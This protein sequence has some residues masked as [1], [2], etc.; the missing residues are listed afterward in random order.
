MLAFRTTLLA[1]AAAL[2]LASS[3]GQKKPPEPAVAPPTDLAPRPAS[4]PVVDSYDGHF[5]CH[6]LTAGE[7]RASLCFPAQGRCERER[8]AAAQDG[9]ETEPCAALDTQA[10]CFQLGGDPNPSQ[11]MCARTVEDCQLWLQIDVEKNGPAA[12]PQSCALASL[13]AQ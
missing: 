10:A 5:W 13:Q 8:Q 3:M 7:S 9:V 2:S 1:L 4:A 11:S 12:A 6:G